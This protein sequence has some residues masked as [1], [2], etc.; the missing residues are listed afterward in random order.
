M[1]GRG[2]GMR[3]LGRLWYCCWGEKSRVMLARPSS[4]NCI[5]LRYRG[6][7]PSFSPPSPQ[8]TQRVY[9]YSSPLLSWSTH[10][11]NGPFTTQMV[12]S[13]PQVKTA[14]YLRSCVTHEECPPPKYPEFAVIGRCVRWRS[15][16]VAPRSSSCA[17]LDAKGQLSECPLSS[18][19]A[20][21]VSL[22]LS[23]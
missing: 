22:F 18:R 16:I 5:L 8:R 9:R 13:P 23:F 11:R 20:S 1:A 15:C 6:L 4:L 19:L 10:P 7:T 2:Q 17:S 21:L 14:T 12:R 3:Q